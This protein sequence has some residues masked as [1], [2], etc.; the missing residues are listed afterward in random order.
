MSTQLL[1]AIGQPIVMGWAAKIE[2]SRGSVNA[3]KVYVVGTKGS[4]AIVLGN[5]W[6]SVHYTNEDLLKAYNNG[7]DVPTFT[8]VS[9]RIVMLN[10]PD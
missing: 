6:G 9:T 2:P 7:E 10:L 3:R 5:A 1:D 8:K 4:K